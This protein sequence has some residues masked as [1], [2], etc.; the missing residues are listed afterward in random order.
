MRSERNTTFAGFV[1]QHSLNP[2]PQIRCLAHLAL[3]T[4]YGLPA[5]ALAQRCRLTN[6]S[7]RVNASSMLV[8]LAA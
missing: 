2:D 8:M 5:E 4:F 7:R 1:Q 3:N 6:L